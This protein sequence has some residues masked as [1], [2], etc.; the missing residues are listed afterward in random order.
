MQDFVR[1]EVLERNC[2]VRVCRRKTR[3]TRQQQPLDQT[4]AGA[5]NQLHG[6]PCAC[7]VKFL[8]C[9]QGVTHDFIKLLASLCECYRSPAAFQQLDAE[10]TLQ[11]L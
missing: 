4:F 9:P 11:F 8:Q 3:Q 10:I 5:D 7:C 2:Q 1:F 6:L